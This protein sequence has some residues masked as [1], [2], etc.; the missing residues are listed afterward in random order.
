MTDPTGAPEP[1]AAAP[2]TP[3]A[4]PASATDPA[5]ELARV[6]AE[7]ETWKGHSRNWETKAKANLDA[8][9]AAEANKELL[10]KVAGALGLEGATPDP[11][12]IAQQLEAAKAQTA[13]L[14]RERAVLL[15]AASNG[16]DAA[17]LL[18]S[19]AFLEQMAG[20]DPSDSMA[21][22]EAVKAAV[23]SN[24]RYA[25]AQPA[26]AP[27]AP[28]AASP[29]AGFAAPRNSEQWTADDVAKASPAQLAKAMRENKLTAYL[30]T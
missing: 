21:V 12:A 2:T 3:P 13:Q 15:A 1:A 9:R 27:A 25:G 16:A 4:P 20:I 23:A 29:T 28:P 8:A 24:P 30:S 14:A 19:R 26:P 17:A 10:A 6:T 18:D 7:L 5:A 11:A 22:A